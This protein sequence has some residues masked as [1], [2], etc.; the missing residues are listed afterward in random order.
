[1]PRVRYH[2]VVPKSE[3]PMLLSRRERPSRLMRVAS[4]GTSTA[5]APLPAP[6]AGPPI[7]MTVTRTS[8]VAQETTDDE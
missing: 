4:H 5:E 7:T 1:M 6:V 3:I 2:V 8:R